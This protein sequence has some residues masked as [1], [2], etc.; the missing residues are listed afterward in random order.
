MVLVAEQMCLPS[1]FKCGNRLALPHVHRKS[2]LQFETHD[3]EGPFHQSLL[4]SWHL[5]MQSVSEDLKLALGMVEVQVV[6][7]DILDPHHSGTSIRTRA[8]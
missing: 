6:W 2:I 7:K 5:E 8:F 4:H 3:R 1:C